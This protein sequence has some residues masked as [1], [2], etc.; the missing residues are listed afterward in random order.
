[1][2]YHQY[3]V[4]KKTAIVRFSKNQLKIEVKNIGSNN[5]F[6]RKENTYLSKEGSI[7]E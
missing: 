4:L 7:H 1:M 6:K 2:K 3:H 5:L